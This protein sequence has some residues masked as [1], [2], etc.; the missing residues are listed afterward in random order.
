MSLEDPT[1][2]SIALWGQ[3]NHVYMFYI[4]FDIHLMIY[5]LWCCYW[6]W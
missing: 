1:V 5:Y 4:M 2:D 6:K 3:S